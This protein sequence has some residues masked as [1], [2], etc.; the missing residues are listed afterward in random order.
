[1]EIKAL[2]QDILVMLRLLDTVGKIIWFPADFVHLP[3]DRN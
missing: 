2:K 3:T 1:M